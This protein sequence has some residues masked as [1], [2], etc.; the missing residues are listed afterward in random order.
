MSTKIEKC[1]I[2]E[3]NRTDSV[4]YGWSRVIAP[5]MYLF[6]AILLLLYE[7]AT[8]VYIHIYNK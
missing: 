8:Q 3:G 5:K 6:T 2:E 7:L 1:T 4:F